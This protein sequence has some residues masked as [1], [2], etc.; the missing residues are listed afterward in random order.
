MHANEYDYMLTRNFEKSSQKSPKQT[1]DQICFYN[2]LRQD[3]KY[4]KTLSSTSHKQF[5][6]LPKKDR[7]DYPTFIKKEFIKKTSPLNIN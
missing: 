4:E 6:T 5:N 1:L 3:P 7:H 2:N